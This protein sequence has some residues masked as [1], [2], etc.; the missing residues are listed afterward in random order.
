MV[1]EMGVSEQDAWRVGEYLA[2]KRLRISDQLLGKG[3]HAVVMQATAG[4]LD[5]VGQQQ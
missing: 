5:I 4:G 2:G 1:K 3:G